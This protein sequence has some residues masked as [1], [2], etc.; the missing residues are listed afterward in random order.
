MPSTAEEKQVIAPLPDIKKENYPTLYCKG[1]LQVFIDDAR[2]KASEVPD[3]TTTK[4]RARIKSLAS[5]V[6]SSKTAVTKP[7]REYLKVIKATPKIIED[8]LREFSREMDALRDLTRKPLTDWE[9]DQARIK[10]EEEERVAA[11]ALKIEVDKCHELA[12]LMNEKLDRDKADAAALAESDRM[13][14]ERQIAEQ[15]AE[16]ATEKALKQV[17]TEKQ[18]IIRDADHEIGLFLNNEFDRKRTEAKRVADAKAAELKLRNEIEECHEIALLTNSTFDRKKAENE[19][20]PEPQPQQEPTQQPAVTPSA[21]PAT[22]SLNPHTATLAAVKESLMEWAKID[23]ETARRVTLA[24]HNKRI[25][26]TSISYGQ[27]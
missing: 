23:E 19:T 21:Q 12:L 7:G 3:L 17:E 11:E 6:S 26:N 14:H 20:K 15:A 27:P 4:G 24:I 18:R 22:P 2:E 10:K 16:E 13:A 1:G 9:A 25:T 5:A 8:E